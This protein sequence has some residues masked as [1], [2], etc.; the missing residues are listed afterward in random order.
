MKVAFFTDA[1]LPFITGVSVSVAD[2]AKSL[3]DRGHEIHI[4]APIPEDLAFEHPNVHLKRVPSISAEWFYPGFRFANPVNRHIHRYVQDREIDLVQFHTPFLIG[5]LGMSIA[6]HLE[7]PL[8]G[9]YHS[10]VDAKQYRKNLFLHWHLFDGVAKLFIDYFYDRCDLV[11][12]PTSA[13]AAQLEALGFHYPTRVISNGIDLQKFPEGGGAEIRASYP[14]KIVLSVGR[15]AIEKNLMFLLQAWTQLQ[16]EAQLILIGGGPLQEELQDYVKTEGLEN[17]HF[18][19]MIP[20][21]ELIRSGYHRA[22]DVFVMTSMIEVQG[23]ALMEAQANGLVSVG[24]N[25][26]GTKDLIVDGENGFLIEPGDQ[27]HF[28][29]VIRRLLG[30]D[31]LRERMREATLTQIQKHD[32]QNVAK[33]WEGVYEELVARRS[34]ATY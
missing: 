30:D 3:A 4:I 13:Y 27:D 11:S 21:D 9:T 28:V 26:G 8:V 29:E 10:A 15:M 6:R 34:C 2:L 14:G 19:G 24:I 1:F 12:V 33:E 18:L 22:A 16:E 7:L 32:L 17:V 25:S 20:H 23:L 31:A 5:R